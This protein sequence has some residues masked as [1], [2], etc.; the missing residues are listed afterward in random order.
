MFDFLPGWLLKAVLG[1]ASQSSWL[2]GKINAL[3]IN[4]AVNVC[5]HRPH[6]WSTVHDYVSWTSL[7]DQRFSARHLPAFYP[8]TAPPVAT[9]LIGLFKR[10]SGAQRLSDKSKCL[11][12]AFAQYFTDR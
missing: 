6:P 3:I 9:S 8:T 11:F 1:L 7:S 10:S 4:A 5:R 2:D 12:L